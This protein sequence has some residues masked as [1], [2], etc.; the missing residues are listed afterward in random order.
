MPVELALAGDGTLAADVKG[1]KRV[2]L[3]CIG[4]TH[5]HAKLLMDLRVR[6][7]RFHAPIL[8]GGARISV[9]VGKNCRS[10]DRLH[11][12]AERRPSARRSCGRRDRCAILGQQHAGNP[13]E[14]AGAGDIALDNGDAGRL[15]RTDRLM[16][17]VDGCL[18]Q[19]ECRRFDA[20]PDPDNCIALH[21]SAPMIEWK[22][23]AVPV[24]N[25]PKQP[26]S[27]RKRT[28][29]VSRPRT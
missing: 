8:E 6:R 5:D 26:A 28:S 13:V 23:Q 18:F 16:Q 10:F 20:G 11:R 21:I 2:H 19:T 1:C 14:G 25:F 4:D 7:R 15:P 27:R 24:H 22:G 29:P 12:E 9:E 17:A 3:A